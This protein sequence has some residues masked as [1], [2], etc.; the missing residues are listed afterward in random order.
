MGN[1]LNF[2][3]VC[4]V[5]VDPDAKLIVSGDPGYVDRSAFI[6]LDFDPKIGVDNL[7]M[8]RTGAQLEIWNRRH[9]EP[10]PPI[11]FQSKKAEKLTDIIIHPIIENDAYK[12]VIKK[13]ELGLQY[14]A[15]LIGRS[16]VDRW[17]GK[18]YE[19]LHEILIASIELPVWDDCA[20]GSYEKPQHIELWLDRA[21]A[22]Q[23]AAHSSFRFDP[24]TVG[25]ILVA[26]REVRS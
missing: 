16:N 23:L 4:N 15:N 13:R 7:T 3:P 19:L 21:H 25:D 6:R 10:A 22:D 12:L 9:T 18:A 24:S 26:S 14:D 1:L 8:D 20:T 11:L 17:M 2:I 5:L